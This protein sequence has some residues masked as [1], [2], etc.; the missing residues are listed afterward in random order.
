M[1]IFLT[2]CSMLIMGHGICQLNKQSFCWHPMSRKA[3]YPE[4][5]YTNY[6]C[7]CPIGQSLPVCLQTTPKAPHVA[8]SRQAVSLVFRRFRHGSIRSVDWKSIQLSL[9][10]NSLYCQSYITPNV[11][12]IRLC[13]LEISPALRFWNSYRPPA[14]WSTSHLVQ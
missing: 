13:I 2:R 10:I 8:F 1:F 11:C 9:A 6:C 3:S 12:I 14:G 7:V 5:R 4:R